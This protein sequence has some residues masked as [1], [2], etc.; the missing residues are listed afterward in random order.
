MLNLF[1]YG[2]IIIMTDQ[3]Q[4][5]SYQR[6]FIKYVPF[7]VAELL[8]KDFILYEHPIVKVCLKKILNLSILLTDYSHWKEST[9]NYKKYNIKYYK[10]LGTST[11][12]ES[13]EYFKSLKLNTYVSSYKKILIL[14]LM[15]HLIKNLPIIEK[16]G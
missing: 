10:G 7:Y 9:E 2:K 4:V 5:V 16:N 12:S 13:K 3:D 6:T 15:S 14:P 1:R 11:A 8:N